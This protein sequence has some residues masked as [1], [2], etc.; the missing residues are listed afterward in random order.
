[1]DISKNSMKVCVVLNKLNVD[2]FKKSGQISFYSKN[3]TDVS[4]DDAR[5]MF[6]TI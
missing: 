4:I 6:A 1:M 5:Y 2:E 3:K